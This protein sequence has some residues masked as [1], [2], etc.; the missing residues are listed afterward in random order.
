MPRYVTLTCGGVMDEA[1]E[2][3]HPPMD[4][5]GQA[6]GAWLAQAHSYADLAGGDVLIWRCWPELHTQPRIGIY[7]RMVI[8]HRLPEKQEAA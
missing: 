2:Q 1:S 7:S 3:R 6:I 4:S 8:T 5:E